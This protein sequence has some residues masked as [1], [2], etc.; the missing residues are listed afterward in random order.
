M[1]SSC[2][3]G[4]AKKSFSIDVVQI[5]QLS[6]KLKYHMCLHKVEWQLGLVIFLNYIKELRLQDTLVCRSKLA[7]QCDDLKKYNAY[8]ESWAHGAV[9]RLLFMVIGIHI[10]NL[11]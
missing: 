9:Y 4:N 2:K 11:L 7:I 8:P 1:C 10:F 5:D 6:K 3:A